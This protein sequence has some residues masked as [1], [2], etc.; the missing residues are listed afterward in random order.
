M[1]AIQRTDSPK[2]LK[3]KKS[4]WT[5][6]LL[7]AQTKQQRCKAEIK[8]RHKEIKEALSAMFHGKCAYCESKISH[9]DYGYI[10]HYRPK[11]VFPG[12][13]FEWTNLLLACG[14][15]NGAGYKGDNFPEEEQDGP[16]VNPCDDDPALN[17]SFHYDPICRIASVYGTTPRGKTT[18]K[19]LGLNR[20]E[21]R[22][23]RSCQVAKLHVLAHYAATDIEAKMLFEEAIKDSAEYAAFARTLNLPH[24]WED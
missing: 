12:L 17:F 18:E 21:L 1:I 13:T 7:S 16:I 2:I 19:L 4:E 9:V 22:A 11:S 23:Y 8:Y 20:H 14:V 3:K 15:C 6:N 5:E 24:D 10:E